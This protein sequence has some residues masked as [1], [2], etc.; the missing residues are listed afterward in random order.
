MPI[1][2]NCVKI[3]KKRNEQLKV[4]LESQR[5]QLSKRKREVWEKESKLGEYKAQ[6]QELKE[7][8]DMEL[9]KVRK[10]CAK[11]IREQRVA[12]KMLQKRF[13]ALS[14]EHSTQ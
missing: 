9:Q 12:Y 8:L 4:T 13:D 10:E 11:E 3:K 14:A 2:K 1:L 7:G 6:N 5:I